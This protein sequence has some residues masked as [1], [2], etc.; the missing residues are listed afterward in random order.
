MSR[1]I[2]EVRKRIAKRKQEQLRNNVVPKSHVADTVPQGEPSIFEMGE[3][4]EQIQ[5]GKGGFFVK[6]LLSVLLVAFVAMMFRS[7]TK[8]SEQVQSVVSQVMEKDFQFAQVSKWYE[9]RFGAP[10]TFLTKGEDNTD[11]LS[12]YAV[13]ASGKVL[14]SFQTNGQGILIETAVDANVE[15]IDEGVVVFVGEKS[16]IGNAVVI[17]HVDGSESWYG[18]LNDVSVNVYDSV[19]KGETIAKVSGENSDGVGTYYFAIKMDD[20]FIDPSKVIPFE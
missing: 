18:D 20:A 5:L 14:E 3:T 7:N 2:D 19:E 13:P 1:N 16:G 11:S 10:L 6:I 12:D 4:K 9:D 15:A 17:Q 8:M